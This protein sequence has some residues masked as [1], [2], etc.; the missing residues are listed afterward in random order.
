MSKKIRLNE[1]FTSWKTAGIFSALQSEN[2]PWQADNIS[3]SLDLEYHGNIS[4]QKVISPLLSAFLINGVLP[5]EDLSTLAHAIFIMYGVNWEKEWATLL[6]EYNPIENYSM[7]EEMT[8]D[9]TVD[10]Y[11]KTVTRTDNL[12]HTKTGSETNTPNTTETN[13]P[14]LQTTEGNKVFGFNSSVGV[15]S[16]SSVSAATGTNTI[17]K[18]GTETLQHNVTDSDTGTQT[19]R[20]GGSDTHT[21][22][23]TL[24][25]SGNIGVTTSQQMLQSERDLWVW[26]FFREIVFPDIDRVLTLGIY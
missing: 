13:T 9:T 18:T 24:T 4:G 19:H 6:A 20:D 3:L 7:T 22:N 5:S 10:E 21:R 11:G 8:D 17:T 16:D 26:N 12:Q 2:V 15:D 25:R 1:V 14:N 23:Y